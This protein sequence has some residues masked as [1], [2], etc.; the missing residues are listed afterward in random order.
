MALVVESAGLCCSVGATLA[1]A[2]HAVRARVDHFQ[3][4]E[5]RDSTGLPVVVARLK[6][7]NDLW[8]PRRLA[9]WIH[10]SVEDCLQGAQQRHQVSDLPLFWL[11][12]EPA[13]RGANPGWYRAAYE[14]AQTLMGGSFH[15][16]SKLF[17]LGKA[18][19]PALLT[20]AEQW[21]SA[22]P[23]RAALVLGADTLLE[24]ADIGQYLRAQRLLVGENSDGFIPGEAAATLLL[25]PQLPAPVGQTR[26]HVLGWGA[27]QEPG[28]SDGSVPTRSVGL[29]DAL[30]A[31]MERSGL[32]FEQIGF[33][34]SDQ[35]GEAWFAKE[36]AS[37][38]ARVTPVGG[39]K[40]P[41]QT[42]ADCIGEVGAATG[43]AML[44][45]LHALSPALGRPPY[46]PAMTGLL[47]CACDGD[48]RAA[49]VVAFRAN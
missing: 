27:G 45:Y 15:P 38:L 17:A 25:R 2:A 34:F 14:H 47:H 23:G 37:A 5:F 11:G 13:R 36:A 7:D 49:A 35:N 26:L 8:G 30:R 28:R 10:A 4:S 48:L 42:L 46:A 18:G 16:D 12:P 29:T 22:N 1:S 39:H 20:H 19:L 3:R 9:Q 33:R 24:S 6:V 40:L 44:A 21:L 43:P 32:A 31:A 41:V